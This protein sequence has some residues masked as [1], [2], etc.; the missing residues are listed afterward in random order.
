LIA[1]KAFPNLASIHRGRWQS[2][3]ERVQSGERESGVGGKM[4]SQYVET[5]R[6][7]AQLPLQLAEQLVPQPAAQRQSER[8]RGKALAAARASGALRARDAANSQ[9]GRSAYFEEAR[10][11]AASCAASR[12]ARAAQPAPQGCSQPRLCRPCE[13]FA[14]EGACTPTLA[15]YASSRLAPSRAA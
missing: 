15:V 3:K 14:P 1:E 6:R 12:A 4:S 7:A 11:C 13:E 8:P 9:A 5:V 2:S 10:S